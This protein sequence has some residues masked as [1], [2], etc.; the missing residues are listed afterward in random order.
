MESTMLTNEASECI[1]SVNLNVLDKSLTITCPEGEESNLFRATR[2]L[3][4]KIEKIKESN[5]TLD[6]ERIA[7]IAALNLAHEL[8]KLQESHQE[9]QTEN[10]DQILKII[11]LIDQSLQSV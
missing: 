4:E 5:R 10:S 6:K 11:D 2:Y 7:I 8:I 9:A 3:N 1:K